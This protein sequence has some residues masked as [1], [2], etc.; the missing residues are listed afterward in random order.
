MVQKQA[1]ADPDEHVRR[2]EVEPLRRAPEYQPDE[3]DLLYMRNDLFD[4]D[5]EDYIPEAAVPQVP[6]PA[7]RPR[8]N[9]NTHA[10]MN[11]YVAE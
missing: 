3:T 8:R 11:D 7:A 1:E 9:I 5:E 2:P 6:V 4:S 10:W